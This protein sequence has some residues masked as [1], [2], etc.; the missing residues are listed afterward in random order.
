M[1]APCFITTSVGF[2]PFQSRAASASGLWDIG[3]NRPLEAFGTD[4]RP[5]TT[6]WGHPDKPPDRARKRRHNPSRRDIPCT[7]L[8]GLATVGGGSIPIPRAM[9]WADLFRPLRGVVPRNVRPI[10]IFRRA[11]SRV[12]RG[13]PC[14]VDLFRKGCGSGTIP[15]R[16][17]AASR[18]PCRSFYRPDRP[19][20]ILVA[21]AIQIRRSRESDRPISRFRSRT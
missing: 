7:A 6:P 13:F 8:S 21:N 4:S 14:F 18:R 11:P 10:A 5:T 17:F 9:P 3:R 19:G 20:H 15:D 16:A 2:T 1:T 12:T